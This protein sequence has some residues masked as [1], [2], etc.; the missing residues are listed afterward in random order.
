MVSMHQQPRPVREDLGRDLGD[1]LLFYDPAGDRLHVLNATARAVY[2]LCD[3]R[4]SVADVVA[5]FASR[6][7]LDEETARRDVAEVLE[8]MIELHLISLN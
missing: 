3:G 7:A 1:E 8:R 2:L 6:Y 5:T 4:R